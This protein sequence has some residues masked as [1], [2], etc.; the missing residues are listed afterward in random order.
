MSVLK[1]I[2]MDKELQLPIIENAHDIKYEK[3]SG[4]N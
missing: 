4:Q 3:R 2:V 1:N